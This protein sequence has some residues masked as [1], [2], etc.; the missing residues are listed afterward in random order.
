MRSLLRSLISTKR[1]LYIDNYSHFCHIYLKTFNLNLKKA[2]INH[3]E[4]ILGLEDETT[5][6]SI[7]QEI[8]QMKEPFDKLWDMVVKFQSFYEKWMNGPI[9]TV[10]P[11]EVD[12]QVDH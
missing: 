1:F 4:K 9:L 6:Y 8:I 11:E 10:N 12:E 5:D 2:I 7:I 3:E